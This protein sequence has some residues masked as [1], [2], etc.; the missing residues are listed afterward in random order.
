MSRR[1]NCWD[2]APQESFF[3]PAKDE[4]YLKKCNVFTDLEAEIED[5]IDYYNNDRPQWT[6]NKMIPKEYHQFLINSS[7]AGLQ[8]LACL[9][10]N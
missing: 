5:Y 10:P 6:M 4:L 9:L 1:G 8:L 2:N 3:G 7:T